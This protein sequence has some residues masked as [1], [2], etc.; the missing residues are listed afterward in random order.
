MRR[1]YQSKLE[2]SISH[3][4]SASPKLPHASRYRGSR[5]LSA[6]PLGHLVIGLVLSI[7]CSKSHDVTKQEIED[8]GDSETPDARAP[9]VPD[10]GLCAELAA[11]QCSAEQRC[12]PSPMRSLERCS[13]DL[14]QSCQQTAYLD[15][16]AMSQNSNFDASAA[17]RAFDALEQLTLE[18]DLSIA[19]WALSEDGLRGIFKGSLERDETC[20]PVGGASADRGIV[21]AAISSCRQADDLACLPKGLLGEWT[22]VPRQAV[23]QSCLTDD[24]CQGDSICNNAGQPALGSCTA[25]LPLGAACTAANQCVSLACDGEKCVEPDVQ[26]VYCPA[27]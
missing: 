13:A 25:R 24:N 3:N 26:S 14:T 4:Y 11:I 27:P 9:E 17:E 10:D 21:A 19:R 20:T 8:A 7:S 6:N 2:S 18:C 12:C 1:R 23:G 22:C 16:I 5:P 15:P